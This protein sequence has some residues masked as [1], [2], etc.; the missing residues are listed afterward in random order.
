MYVLVQYTRVDLVMIERLALK[1]G[2]ER[3]RERAKSKENI[4]QE[5]GWTEKKGLEKGMM[6]RE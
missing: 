4:K 2:R 1:D 6:E 5:K 3:E